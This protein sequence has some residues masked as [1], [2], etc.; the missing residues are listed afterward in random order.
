MQAN[1][2]INA[3]MAMARLIQMQK[4]HALQQQANQSTT[5]RPDIEYD[6][7]CDE[8]EDYYEPEPL[9]LMVNSLCPPSMQRKSWSLSD[10]K[11]E[12][13]KDQIQGGTVS[14]VYRARCITSGLFVIV[15]LTDLDGD[16]CNE[17]LIHTSLNH[18]HIIQCHAAWQETSD[19]GIEQLVMVVELANGGDLASL[20]KDRLRYPQ[21]CF[22]EAEAVHL[23][24][25]PLLK[26]LGHIHSR[27]IVH[28]DIKLENVIFTTSKDHGHDRDLKLKL[29][30]FGIAK[31]L[32]K[33]SRGNAFTPGCGTMAFTA[34]EVYEVG[35]DGYG[36]SADIW[37]LGVLT[38]KL[39]TGRSLF[40]GQGD[41]LRSN[42][43]KGKR[44]E[45]PHSLSQLAR[46]FI[47]EAILDDPSERPDAFELMQHPWIKAHINPD[48]NINRD[49]MRPHR[50]DAM[51]ETMR[52]LMI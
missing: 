46:S 4:A 36:V 28:R 47:S 16:Y 45:L 24:I 1:A 7:Q 22:E 39:L 12:K 49:Q 41:E 17:A 37:S 34:K 48:L 14:E 21:G 38:F 32:S 26:A 44:S 51:A 10:Y 8:T 30:D 5:T 43:I 25:L 50:D 27:G 52:R 20:L 15:K 42:I 35:Q 23:V 18:E 11:F 40:E 6:D 19:D 2:N 31:Q 29:C 13:S 3:I 33:G 9:P